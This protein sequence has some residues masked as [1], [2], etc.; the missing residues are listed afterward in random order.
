MITLCNVQYVE[1]ICYKARA[2]GY[3]MLT[4]LFE[5]CVCVCVF[6]RACACLCEIQK[7]KTDL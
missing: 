4:W 6:V 3:S 5:A 2:A 7:E 1:L